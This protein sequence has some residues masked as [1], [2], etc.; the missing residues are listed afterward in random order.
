M[1]DNENTTARTTRKA[2][3]EDNDARH[4]LSRQDRV[5][6]ER[7]AAQVR[8]RRID[9]PRARGEAEQQGALDETALLAAAAQARR[10]ANNL[11]LMA[12]TISEP[13]KPARTRQRFAR[14]ALG[15]ARANPED[16]FVESAKTAKPKQRLLVSLIEDEAAGV[17]RWQ[18]VE[19]AAKGDHVVAHGGDPRPS[20]KHPSAVAVKRAAATI[21]KGDPDVGESVDHAVD[22][23]LAEFEALFPEERDKIDRAELRKAILLWLDTDRGRRKNT[24]LRAKK[25]FGGDKFDHLAKAIAA[26]SFAT[27]KGVLESKVLAEIRRDR[28]GYPAR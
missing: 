20:S 13:K 5:E 4:A 19:Q 27:T 8:R 7:L 26:T 11:L 3:P 28:K 6:I 23:V 22:R 15:Y 18:W 21:E 12:E 14:R 25:A 10:I 24:D 9:R 17:K 1:A 16:L 2:R